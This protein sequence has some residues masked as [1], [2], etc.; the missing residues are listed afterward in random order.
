MQDNPID[1][2]I[3]TC[4]VPYKYK[5]ELHAGFILKEDKYCTECKNRICDENLTENLFQCPSKMLS[6]K[7]QKK[8]LNCKFL[9]FQK[10]QKVIREIVLILKF[11]ISGYRDWILLLNTNLNKKR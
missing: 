8:E 7:F 6:K 1:I 5:E 3:A 10:K 4:P 11:L 9:A 2:Y